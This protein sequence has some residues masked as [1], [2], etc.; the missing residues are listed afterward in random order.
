[1]SLEFISHE[2]VPM[3]MFHLV[4]RLHVLTYISDHLNFTVYID[5]KHDFLFLF[6]F[7]DFLLLKTSTDI[8]TK[9]TNTKKIRCH[10]TF[11]LSICIYISSDI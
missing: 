3:K 8:A 9:T 1:M 5:E 2:Q 7:H 6:Q 4:K 11:I 10:V